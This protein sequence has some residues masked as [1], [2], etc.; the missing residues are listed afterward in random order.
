MTGMIINNG[1]P[2]AVTV[3]YGDGEKRIFGTLAKALEFADQLREE[4]DRARVMK[5]LADK[6]LDEVNF[7]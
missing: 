2:I 7:L 6:P 4:R 3:E 1:N 5:S